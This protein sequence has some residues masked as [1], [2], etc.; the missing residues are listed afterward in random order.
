[1]SKKISIIL[2][3]RDEK[4][5]IAICIKKINRTL[6]GKDYEIIVSDSSSDGSDRIA[7]EL[8][9]KLVRH[10]IGYGDALITGMNN[11]S[12]GYLIF[13]DCDCS[14]D[15]S[16]IPKFI[17][18]LNLGYDFVIG[19]RMKGYIKKGAMPF[20]HR[21]IGVPV[22]TYLINFKF[23]SNFSDTHS[24]FRGIKKEAYKKLDLKC[25]GMEFAS[26]MVIKAKKKNLS[27]SEI[28]INYSLRRGNKKIR[29]FRD[30]FR[31]LVY[32][33]KEKRK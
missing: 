20:L 11:A 28:P 15:F 18:K 4:E 31:H 12:G 5:G 19:S 22:L 3:C 6:K 7:K 24:G 21:Y 33:L 16:E 27:I 26:E 29:T 1:M 2:P 23:N 32:I 25:K 17:E 10:K 13:A 30:G 9:A 8:G 14:Y